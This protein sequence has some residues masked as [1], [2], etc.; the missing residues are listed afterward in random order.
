M[1]THCS[2]LRTYGLGRELH[3]DSDCVIKKLGAL[4]FESIIESKKRE[5]ES[6]HNE[7]Q[8]TEKEIRVIEGL[9]KQN[10]PPLPENRPDFRLGT[11]IWVFDSK[12]KRWDR[13]VVVSGC[14]T[15]EGCVSFVLDVYPETKGNPRGCGLRNPGILKDWEYRYFK[16]NLLDFKEWLKLSDR[17]Y[18]GEWI[19]KDAYYQALEAGKCGKG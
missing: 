5:I 2:L 3:W 12:Q 1:S 10:K 19:D 4:D 16:V 15:H 17:E 18:N 13:G 9:L 14:R 7:I 6:A 8:A 11:V